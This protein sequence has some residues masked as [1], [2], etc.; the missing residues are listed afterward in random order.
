M[1]RA[2]AF[3]PI[4]AC[5]SK[6]LFTNPQRL[7]VAKPPLR[8]QTLLACFFAASLTF[9]PASV[10]RTSSSLAAALV[11][12]ARAPCRWLPSSAGN[13]RPPSGLFSDRRSV[14]HRRGLAADSPVPLSSFCLSRVLLRERWGRLHAPSGRGVT[15]P[16]AVSLVHSLTCSCEPVSPA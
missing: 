16:F 5:N 12:L 9:A 6:R 4:G 10:C 13:V 8:V 11:S 3:A 7:P 1:L 15:T 2:L 14:A